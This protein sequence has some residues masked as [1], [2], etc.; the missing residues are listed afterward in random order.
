MKSQVQNSSQAVESSQIL[1]LVWSSIDEPVG[2][3]KSSAF[4]RDGLLEQINTTADSSD[5][6][7]YSIRYGGGSVSKLK[8][9]SYWMPN[10]CFF[11]LNICSI[12]ITGDEPFLM[13]KNQAI[14]HVESLG[15]VLH[16]FVNG[17]IAGDTNKHI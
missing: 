10:R 6:L 16:A 13:D 9:Y 11:P 5:Y 7:W 17:E 1:Q 14:L 4:A 3:S 12:E 15:H 2:I 8:T